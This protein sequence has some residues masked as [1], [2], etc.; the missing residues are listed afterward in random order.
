M[1]IE[2]NN[3][4]FYSFHGCLEEESVIGGHYTVDV[5]IFTDLDKQK[6]KDELSETVDYC[7]IFEA[8]KKEMAIRSKLIEHAAQRIAGSLLSIN[9]KITDVEV[10]VTKISPPMNGDVG[11][12][13]VRLRASRSV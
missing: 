4:R 10:C 7:D 6:I 2:L 9:E 8:V 1:V 12:V 3:L 13:S 5:K 11:S